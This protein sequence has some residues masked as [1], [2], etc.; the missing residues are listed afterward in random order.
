[1]VAAQSRLG[2]GV[3]STNQSE[4][5]LRRNLQLRLAQLSLIAGLLAC[6]SAG[7]GGART[8]PN[9]ITRVEIYNSGA[10]NAYELV[11][12]LRPNW[13]RATAAGSIGG[14]VVQR[15]MVLVYLDRQRLEDIEALKTI[16]V[17]GI[18]SAQW[19]EA[20]RVQTV[21]PDVP[22]GPIAG[23]IVLRMRK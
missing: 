2:S 17:D 7:T 1:M 14:G 23:A 15:Q 11:S 10:S 21:L 5:P 4:Y 3:P 16:S 19:L 12:R 13:L 9:A 20:A 18:D 6:A 8:D 22:T